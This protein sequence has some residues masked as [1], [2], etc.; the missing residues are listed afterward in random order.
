M[1]LPA[2]YYVRTVSLKREKANHYSITLQGVRYDVLR[3][4]AEDHWRILKDGKHWDSPDHSLSQ[5]R[6]QLWREFVFQAEAHKEAPRWERGYR[7]WGYWLGQTRVGH[8]GLSPREYPP[9]TYSWDVTLTGPYPAD[10]EG[11]ETSLKAAKHQVEL[12]YQE[13]R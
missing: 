6:R 13:H 3:D 5:I 9:V 7:S 2:D 11:V 4:H 10:S 8:V 1:E 12:W